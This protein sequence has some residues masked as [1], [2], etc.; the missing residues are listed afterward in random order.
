MHTRTHRTL[1]SLD[2]RVHDAED[3]GSSIIVRTLEPRRITARYYM[4]P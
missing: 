3:N 1:E 4:R 2:L